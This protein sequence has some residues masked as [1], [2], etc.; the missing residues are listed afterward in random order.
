MRAAASGVVVGAGGGRAALFDAQCYP[1]AGDGV[2]LLFNEV[3]DRERQARDLAER[4][5]ENVR[6]RELA[7]A[8]AAE[9]DVPA[10]LELLCGAAMDLCGAAGATVAEL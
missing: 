4:S 2:L 10:L 3:G 1:V 6:L 7:R 8:M 9:R 5:A